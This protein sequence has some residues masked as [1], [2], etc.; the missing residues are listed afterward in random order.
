ML[1]VSCRPTKRRMQKVTN[2]SI[3]LSFM[4]YMLSALFGYLTFYGRPAPAPAPADSGCRQ[5]LHLHSSSLSC[6]SSSVC[7]C[8][9]FT[10]H[11]ESE[12]LLGYSTY[13]P[14]DVLVMTVRFAILLSVLLTVPLIHFPVSAQIHK[15]HLTKS[16]LS[17]AAAC[18]SRRVSVCA[19]FCCTTGAQSCD[20][21]P[22]RRSSLLLANSHRCD[23]IHP[24]AG[25]ADGH[26]CP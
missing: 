26:L 6:S 22:V 24:G 8:L 21:A 7:V 9:L 16:R 4:L 2:V 17:K 5:R 1:L 3:S 25:G 13:L 14:R 23:F 11:V 12:L 15:S 18:F 10:A 20:P 19:R